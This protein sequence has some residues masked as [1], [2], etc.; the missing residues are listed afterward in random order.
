QHLAT[1][2]DGRDASSHGLFADDLAAA[3]LWNQDGAKTE[4]VRRPGLPC[5]VIQASISGQPAAVFF[6][7][8]GVADGLMRE[9]ALFAYHAS[10][11]WVFWQSRVS[12]Q[13]SIPHGFMVTAWFRPLPLGAL[14]SGGQPPLWKAFTLPG[15]WE[16]RSTVLQPPSR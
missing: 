13:V 2:L 12:V 11:D 3:L 14:R 15:W 5:E 8:D 16:V 9:V 1:I 10:I 4:R 6:E 7:H